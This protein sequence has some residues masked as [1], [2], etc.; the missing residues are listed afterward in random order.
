M[1]K[2]LVYLAFL[3]VVVSLLPGCESSV[4]PSTV[5]EESFGVISWDFGDKRYLIEV[6]EEPY[7]LG[8]VDTC[9]YT[10]NSFPLPIGKY[11]I[12]VEPDSD[13]GSCYYS[14]VIDLKAGEEFDV[15]KRVLA[16]A[17][18]LILY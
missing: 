9:F 15:T 4:S 10:G 11:W 18:S 5:E 16:L 1:L 13:S 6:I 7:H 2:F 14:F 3:A 17:D 8:C 12:S